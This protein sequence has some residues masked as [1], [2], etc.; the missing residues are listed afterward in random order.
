MRFGR[1]EAWHRAAASR[2]GKRGGWPGVGWQW[3]GWGDVPCKPCMAL[4]FQALLAFW[5]CLGRSL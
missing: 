1:A 5:G 4:D 2:V 3:V